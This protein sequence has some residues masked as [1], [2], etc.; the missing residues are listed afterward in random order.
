MTALRRTLVNQRMDD[1]MEASNHKEP[2]K[3]QDDS[4]VD[5][6]APPSGEERRDRYRAC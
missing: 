5:V 3:E 6:E 2:S 1:K 4:A